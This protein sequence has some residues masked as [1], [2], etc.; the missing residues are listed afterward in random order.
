[1]SSSV[2]GSEI[3]E[4]RPTQFNDLA[5][6]GMLVAEEQL[7]EMFE[8]EASSERRKE[9]REEASDSLRAGRAEY[10]SWPAAKKQDLLDLRVADELEK[11]THKLQSRREELDP[12]SA[13]SEALPA[14][15]ELATI[16]RELEA[17]QMQLQRITKAPRF[18]GGGFPS[19]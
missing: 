17:I 15:A 6:S 1:R 3:G 10:E 12:E 19:S 5:P 9:L 16:A 7:G 8:A 13:E 14:H 18:F 4:V 2:R 11:L